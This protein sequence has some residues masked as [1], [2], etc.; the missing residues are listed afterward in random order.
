MRRIP[1][2]PGATPLPLVLAAIGGVALG[3]LA[4]VPTLMSRAATAPAKVFGAMPAEVFEDDYDG[5]PVV[6]AELTHVPALAP[7]APGNRTHNVRID[8]MAAEIEIAPGVRY[9]AWTFGGAVPGPVLHVREGDRVF[10]TMKNRSNTAVRITPPDAGASPFLADLANGPQHAVPTV[11][12]MPHSMD[13]HAGTVAANDKWRIILPGQTIRFEW[14]AN[15]PGVFLYHCGM[16]PA[17][18]HLSMGQYGVVVVSPRDGFP[19]DADVARSYVLVQSEFYL[20]HDDD[21]PAE[22]L[23]TFDMEA[24]LKKQPSQVLFNGHLQTLADTKFVANAGERVRFY[25]NNA[26]PS[27]GSSLHVVGA[28][29]DRVFMEGNPRNEWFGMQTVPFGASSGGVLELIA[30]EEGHYVLVDHEFADAQHGA[31]A[32]LKVHGPDGRDT[33]PP[34]AQMN[35]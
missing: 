27:D 12:P 1:F 34:M 30:P 18:M 15:Y 35:H 6:G 13:F 20:S 2:L 16:A 4:R 24:A 28:I 22:T 23:S 19:T 21:D 32:Y 29:F 10:F 33:A 11:M 17:L 7:L 31:V 25:F 14:Q 26:G 5:P 3:G 8:V 9:D